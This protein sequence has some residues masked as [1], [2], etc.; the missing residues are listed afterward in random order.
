M[1]IGTSADTFFA[2]TGESRDHALYKVGLKLHMPLD[3][4]WAQST[5]IVILQ[6]LP[7]FPFV[8][9]HR[10]HIGDNRYPQAPRERN[11]YLVAN[12]LFRE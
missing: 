1:T 3:S 6:E 12:R 7:G 5:I 9:A 4:I 10:K 11:P 2:A 8:G